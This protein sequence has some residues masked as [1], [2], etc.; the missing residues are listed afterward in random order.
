MVGGGDVPTFY[1]SWDGETIDKLSAF[2]ASTPCIAGTPLFWREPYRVTMD[3][4]Q[5]VP[6]GGKYMA[7]ASPSMIEK[8]TA[9][10]GKCSGKTN[11]VM[12]FVIVVILALLLFGFLSS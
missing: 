3:E 1:V 5:I 11:H 2:S 8:F 6:N 10:E 12:I 4:S 7:C 9:M